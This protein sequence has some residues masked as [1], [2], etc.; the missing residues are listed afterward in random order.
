MEARARSAFE[1][2]IRLKED[3]IRREAGTLVRASLRIVETF[4]QGGRLY[5]FGN[6]GSAADAQHIAAEFINRF[7]VDRAG[8]PALALTTDS[9]ALT[10]IG[11]DSDFT[12]VFSRQL[13][14]LA[15][16]GDLVWA[17][18]T[19]GNSPNVLRG[20]ESARSMGIGSIAFLG[21]DGG[22]AAALA[23]IP[24]IVGSRDTPRIQEVHSVAGHVICELVETHLF[25]SRAD[26]D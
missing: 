11:N 22:G 10:S 18:S 9:S 17:F 1:E 16:P 15:R 14:A 3:F 24:V 5:L 4:R 6:G 13:E 2:S 23:E 26:E 25:G 8:L 12:R 21:G 19:S 7:L 20:L